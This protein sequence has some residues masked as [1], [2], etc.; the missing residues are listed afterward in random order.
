MAEKTEKATP[1][2]LRD[3][4]KKGQVAKSQDFP[5]AFT[6]VVSI[7][8]TL[9]GAGYM[10]NHLATYI[11]GIFTAVSN[12][13]LDLE[14]RGGAYF[15]GAIKVIAITSF[16]I[17]LMVAISGV[18][19]NFLIIGPM[20]SMQAMKFDLKKLNPIEG[21]KQKFKIKVFVELIKSILKIIGAAV[22]IFIAMYKML[23]DVI[24]SSAIPALASAAILETFL[25]RISL[26]VGIFFLAIAIFDLAFQKRTFAKE[27]MMEK[28]ETK[29]EYKDSEGDPM[30]KGKRKEMFRE[31]AY[32]DG[33]R[34]AKK[35]RAVITNPTHIAVAVGYE[36]EGEKVPTIL[37]MG[38]GSMAEKIIEIAVDANVPIM[39]N[40][41]LARQ[42]HSI[43][44]IGDYIPKDTYKAV[45]EVLKWVKQLEDKE[46]NMEIFR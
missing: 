28:H 31:I 42:L 1:K 25:K 17:V 39:R 36:D 5:A 32:S 23:P 22:I 7:F 43:G 3:A 30:I 14:H 27:M 12:H 29:Q 35:A 46:V 21:I 4:K 40:I 15:V 11:I 19:V 38:I 8:G 13:N 9:L 6:F 18:L 20:F 2:K 37:T 44:T 41:D 24:S 45:A 26:Q 34:A 10:Y 16:P 33:P